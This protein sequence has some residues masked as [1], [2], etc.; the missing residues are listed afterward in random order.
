MLTRLRRGQAAFG[1]NAAP[2]VRLEWADALSPNM[3]GGS[4]PR[5]AASLSGCG[6][7]GDPQATEASARCRLLRRIIDQVHQCGFCRA[8]RSIRGP[9]PLNA[10]QRVVLWRD[11]GR[12]PTMGATTATRLDCTATVALS[13]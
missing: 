13:C 6:V 8:T 5:P 11:I 2:F 4:A 10:I 7:L 12:R 9:I 1:R 3:A